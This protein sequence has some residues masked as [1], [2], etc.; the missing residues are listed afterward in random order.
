LA[1]G[2]DRDDILVAVIDIVSEPSLN[3]RIERILK[4]S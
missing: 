3:D 1:S 4:P 2:K